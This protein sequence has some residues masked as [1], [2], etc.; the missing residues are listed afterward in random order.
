MRILTIYPHPDDESFGPAAALA[1]WVAE[2]AELHGV[3]FTRGEHGASS[4]EPTPSTAE[5]A[6]LREQDLREVAELI[7]Y[8]DVEILDFED[9]SLDSITALPELVL[10]RLRQVRPDRVLT[11]GPA[12]ITG[13]ADHRAVSRA[14]AAAF[15]RARAEHVPLKEL[16]FDALNRAAAQRLG[17]ADQLD[18]QANVFVDVSEFHHVKRQ[19]LALHARHIADAVERLTALEREP[20]QVEAFYRAVPLSILVA[21]PYRSGTNDDPDRIEANLRAMNQASLELFRAGH[22]PITGE[23]LALPLVALAG[24]TRMGDAPWDE[25]FHPMGAR[26]AAAADAVLRIGGPS[27]G[28]D[29][30]VEV[31]RAAGKQVFFSL[32]DV[33]P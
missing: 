33:P 8:R 12:G 13:H 11:F 30:M 26:I 19:A 20:L 1:R 23:A 16:F 28:A 4:V 17:V 27:R 5:L 15:A 6:Q 32:D 18:G 10:D 2:G 24:S 29:E 21:G 25:I 9:G 3:W 14:V 31:A 22:L 7:G